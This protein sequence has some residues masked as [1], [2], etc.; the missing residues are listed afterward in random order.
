[1]EG[2]G[3]SVKLFML[4]AIMLTTYSSLLSLSRVIAA[5]GSPSRTHINFRDSKLTRILQPSL[6]GNDKNGNYLLCNSL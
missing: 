4:K 5:L 3:S 2:V 1:M 6:S